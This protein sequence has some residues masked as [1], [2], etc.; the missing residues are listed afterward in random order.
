MVAALEPLLRSLDVSI[1]VRLLGVHAQKLSGETSGALTL[2]D[3]NPDGSVSDIEEHWIPASRAVDSILQKFGDG[4][5]GP[6]SSID[7]PRPGANRYGAP[8]EDR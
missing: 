4:V 3:I 1:G 2:F 5:I 7:G 8:E 6:A